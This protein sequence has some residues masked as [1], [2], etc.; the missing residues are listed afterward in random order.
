MKPMI[1]AG[2][3]PEWIKLAPV[4]LEFRR[5][6]VELII[7]HTGQHHELAYQAMDIFG[8]KLTVALPE[9]ASSWTL[10]R[11]AE[12][13]MRDLPYHLEQYKPDV[14]IVQ[15][16]TTSAMAGA[17]AAFYE[18][19]P[20][21]HVEAGLRTFNLQSPFPEEGNRLIIDALSTFLFPPTQK[22]AF[23]LDPKRRGRLTQVTGNTGIDALRLALQM[24]PTVSYRLP[25]D[26]RIILVTTHRRENFGRLSRLLQALNHIQEQDNLHVYYSVH[27]NPNV[28]TMIMAALET[29]PFVTLLDPPPDFVSWA[30][31]M[32]QADVILTDSGGMQEEAV[33]LGKPVYVLR[34]GT[35]RTEGLE[36]AAWMLDIENE[37]LIER[38]LRDIK[39]AE[40]SMV[41][42]N[43]HA[44]VQIVNCLLDYFEKGNKR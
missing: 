4:I 20:V 7:L 36:G 8:I 41:Y 38:A 21:A 9:R 2:T 13:I 3:R 34:D 11:V 18:G 27:P 31:L 33:Y 5:R 6:G 28:R 10:T 24:E 17:L 15:G 44:A 40:P 43:G 16:D 39:K 30:H 32:R 22:A 26:H 14:V 42:G 23:N 25:P 12:Y 35:E 19:Y 37:E 1:V 29:N